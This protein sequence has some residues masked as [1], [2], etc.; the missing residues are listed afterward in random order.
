[1]TAICILKKKIH[2]VYITFCF[3]SCYVRVKAGGKGMQ[4]VFYFEN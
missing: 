1:M 4:N 2:N 3:L